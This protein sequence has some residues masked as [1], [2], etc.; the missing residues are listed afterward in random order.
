M[1][2]YVSGIDKNEKKKNLSV[3]EERV[4]AMQAEDD[5]QARWHAATSF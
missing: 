4:K 5:R 3:Q 1:C 2:M